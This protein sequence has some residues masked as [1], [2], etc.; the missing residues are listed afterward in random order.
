MPPSM[1]LAVS[2]L[3]NALIR[4]SHAFNLQKPIHYLYPY[5]ASA[6]SPHRLC[7]KPHLSLT[8][9]SIRAGDH[10]TTTLPL[11]SLLQSR[12]MH[13]PSP[14]AIQQRTRSR[15]RSGKRQ[16]I[17]NR[18]P[19]KLQ[20]PSQDSANPETHKLPRDVSIPQLT[21]HPVQQAQT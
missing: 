5:H 2:L 14:A 20:P 1:L 12:F 6:I 13:L 11:P 9:L 10:I 18:I 4:P 17:T 21:P 7:H 15:I 19:Q 8:E 16:K 3:S